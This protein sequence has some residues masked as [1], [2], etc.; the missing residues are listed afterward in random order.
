MPYTRNASLVRENYLPSTKPAPSIIATS[1]W[2]RIG[3]YEGNFY[4]IVSDRPTTVLLTLAQLVGGQGLGNADTRG[5][6]T[7]KWPQE[8]A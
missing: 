4:S 1:L 8:V 2:L 3:S 6:K 7:G 5:G